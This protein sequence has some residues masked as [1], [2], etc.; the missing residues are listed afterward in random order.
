[1][2]EFAEAFLLVFAQLAVGGL[3]ALSIPP[4][5]QLE[6]GF[7]KSTAAVYLGAAL[8]AIVGWT[9]LLL[10]RPSAGNPRSLEI[11]VWAAFGVS[12]ATYLS[13]LWG[14]AVRLRARSYVASLVLGLVALA[15][16]AI[17]YRADTS[18]AWVVYPLEFVAS[19]LV[20][21]S[22]ATGMLLGHWYLIDLGLTL[23]PFRR[24]Q[25]F[26]VASI[27]VQIGVAAAS[28]LFLWL[29]AGPTITPALEKLWS[30][31]A[32]LLGLRIILGPVAAYGLG[33]MIARTLDVPQTMAA[34]GLFYI[35]LLAVVV[36]EIL[37]RTILFRTSL[38][39]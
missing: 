15:T 10:T 14:E 28:I 16:T 38:P 26:F 20:L 29:A 39:L 1:V 37:G 13:S 3:V 22:A 4:F 17:R 23:T 31:H 25:R 11:A 35:A 30:D 2:K 19:A 24:M 12:F 36:G 7:Y 27:H 18:V 6:R 9:Y 5:R 32:L 34:T 8:I 33:W 21:G